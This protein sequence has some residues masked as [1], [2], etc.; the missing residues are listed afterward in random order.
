MQPTQLTLEVAEQTVLG[1]AE[2]SIRVLRELKQLGVNVAIT[3][4]V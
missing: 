4:F 1:N 2:E 3:N